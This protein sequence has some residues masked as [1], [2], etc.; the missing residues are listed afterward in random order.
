MLLW[1]A[2]LT[3]VSG[4]SGR[5]MFGD[6]PVPG[7][8]VT[9][10]SGD[11]TVATT[12]DDHGLFTFSN[13]PDG[14][15]TIRVEMPAFAPVMREVHIG[16]GV[17]T[18][19]WPLALKPLEDIVRENHGSEPIVV[20][21]APE[22]VPSVRREVSASPA[23]TSPAADPPAASD[24]A[25]ADGYLIN[26][27]VN[28]G[29]A[30]LIAQ[31]P[32]FGNN[33]RQGASLYSGSVAF[34]GGTSAWDARPFTFTGVPAARPD[35]RNLK[36]MATFGGPLKITKARRTDPIVFVSLQH[37]NDHNATTERGLVPTAQ[38]RV[39]D[40]SLSL[41]PAGQPVRIVDP[42]S[43][44]AFADNRIPSSR[45]S[46]QA[47]A[48]LT[49]YPLPTID[50]ATGFNVQAPRVSG[51]VQTLLTSRTSQTVRTNDQWIGLF[52]YQRNA[53]NQTS[54]FGFTDRSLVAGVDI[55][56]S[57]SHR[58]S[59]SRSWR[60][61]YQFAR[62]ANE[63]TPHFANRSNVSGDAGI[64]GNDQDPGNWGPPSLQFSGLT[65]LADALPAHTRIV[66]HGA[67][68]EMSWTHGHHNVTF[69][70]DVR[71]TTTDTRSPLNPRGSLS[72]T[73]A[74]TG[75]DVA[76]FLLGLPATAAI[77][78]GSPDRQFH[79]LASDVYF[80]DDWRV[81]P[82]LT[83][84]IGARWEYEAPPTERLG[85]LVNLAAAPDFSSV[86]PIVSDHGLLQSDRAGVQPRVGLAWRP[87][88]GSSLLIRAG[89]GT[90]RTSAIYQPIAQLL[91]Q[92]PPVSTAFS[93]S[94]TV[95]APL[96]LATA[97]VAPSPAAGNTFAVD[98]GLRVGVAHNWQVL[99][100]R[101]LKGFVTLSTSY[102]GTV[103]RH[104][105]QEI[106]PNTYPVGGA[107]RCPTCPSGFVY[108]TSGG[109]SFRHAVQSQLRWR[110][111]RGLAASAQY[112]LSTARDNATAFSGVSLS[113]A[114]I[115][116][117]WRN[118][119]DEEARSHFDQRHQLVAQ[120]QYTTGVGVGAFSQ[121]AGARFLAGWTVA[122]QLTTGSGLPFTP[123]YLAPVPG[124]GVVGS[125]RPSFTGA[126]TTATE[127]RYLNPSAYAA[128]EPGEWGDA[129]RNSVTGPAQFS[130][131]ASL[132]RTFEWTR[133]TFDWRIDVTNVLNRATYTGVNAIV[134][135]PQFGLPNLTSTPRRFSS[136][137]R[138]RF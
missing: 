2:P 11:R 49:Y 104:L 57:W 137:M 24:I 127:G 85:R 87:V 117:D 109:R 101:D 115:A 68:A 3:A 50:G 61:R 63:T 138:L 82:S 38:E 107:N 108:L 134:G 113:G 67:G 119:D 78:T 132:A 53:R 15:W 14:T 92:Q 52:S 16:P 4:Y 96:S 43:G 35:Y 102:L 83:M 130:F 23:T 32:A 135:G 133:L 91:A 99:I 103:G 34:V 114:A 97:F 7:A 123:I 54:L 131:D 116:Q 64:V 122:S 46:A 17:D 89:Y 111:H 76:D 90:Y 1:G 20:A 77:T 65:G 121:S 19:T 59:P 100:Q 93:A 84:Q 47:S 94:G 30:S 28:N 70:G 42:V 106:L 120:V 39:G 81:S 79:A 136:T 26:G 71:G 72:F 51:A 44:E 13:L 74:A 62:T 55:S 6:V 9:A 31:S 41:T 8:D 45:I 129:K 73:G 126:T 10:T 60:L 27:S 58:V 98:P 48:L 37:A 56:L 12:T 112:T 124:T 66:V 95:M 18:V 33:R 40:F 69:G 36:L 88:V 80:T 21:A 128:P 5:V 75:V 86:T 110:L 118:L 25:V 125:L 22:P 105:L 29:A